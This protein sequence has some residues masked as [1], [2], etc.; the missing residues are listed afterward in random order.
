MT[1]MTDFKLPTGEVIPLL[2]Q[3][4]HPTV[5]TVFLQGIRNGRYSDNSIEAKEYANRLKLE[6]IMFGDMVV[7]ASVNYDAVVS[8]PSSRSDATPYRNEVLDENIVDLTSAFSRSCAVKA[9]DHRTT[10]NDLVADFHYQ[11]SGSEQLI[12]SLLIVDETISS[13]KTVA[14]VLECLRTAGL[15]QDC[16]VTVAVHGKMK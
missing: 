9:G 8:P 6:K 3:H 4:K 11:P 5:T 14:A 13:G 15:P 2:F 12:K 10:V 16:L 1:S 7:A